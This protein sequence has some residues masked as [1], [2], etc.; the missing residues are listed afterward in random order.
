MFSKKFLFMMTLLCALTLLAQA[1]CKK[2]EEPRVDEPKS[3]APDDRTEA[4]KE[5]VPEFIQKTKN[6]KRAG[7]VN[8]EV[9]NVTE[10][11]VKVNSII[12]ETGSQILDEKVSSDRDGVFTVVLECKIPSGKF[13]LFIK[14]LNEL[15]KMIDVDIRASDLSESIDRKS[16]E[17]AYLQK[18]I[19]DADER[20][21]GKTAGKLKA[22]LRSRMNEK[23]G[24]QSETVYS[25]LTIIIRQ[26]T[27]FIDSIV[28]G[29]G[30]ASSVL[31][32]LIKIL[33]II[34]I[35][36]LPVLFIWF[37]IKYLRNHLKARLQAQIQAQAQ[38]G[39][40]VEDRE[41]RKTGK[42]KK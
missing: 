14:R 27:G 21:D 30:I 19:K 34:I 42:K 5:A 33:I 7:T 2:K 29:L 40:Q 26:S 18:K 32:V 39:P 22:R 25:R 37:G 9:D 4:D 28:S 41:Q 17:I 15:G 31:K 3:E 6:I 13:S 20:K 16:S 24:I 38:A 35:I 11:N 23:A 12:Q 8:L 10:A 36:V 1:G